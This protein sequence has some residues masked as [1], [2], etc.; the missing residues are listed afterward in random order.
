M[1]CLQPPLG[2]TEAIMQLLRAH[3]EGLRHRD[4][5]LK[6]NG[7]IESS[8]PDQKRLIYN[9]L[10]NLRKARHDPRCGVRQRD[11]DLCLAKWCRIALT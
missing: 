4:I 3:P 8:S 1:L 7:K 6:L 2:A 10:I 11:P 9:T 5:L